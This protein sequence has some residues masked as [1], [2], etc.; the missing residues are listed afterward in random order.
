[1]RIFSLLFLALMLTGCGQTGA[2]PNSAAATVT[3]VDAIDDQ[4]RCHQCGMAITRYP[5]PKGVVQLQGQPAQLAF[6]SSGDM[7]QFL[8]Q[9]QNQR[10]VAQAWVH[11]LAITDWDKPADS[12]FI[13]AKD[14][15]Y[16][17]SSSRH[18]AMGPTLAS[19]SSEQAATEFASAY[20][21]VVLPYAQLTLNNLGTL[22]HKGHGHGQSHGN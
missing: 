16:V 13:H 22:A 18:G 2:E 17:T 3:V 15:W 19:F 5:G 10:Q 14:A 8:L 9:P 1:M 12:A 4:R 20:G 11:D 6:C 7:F 21:G